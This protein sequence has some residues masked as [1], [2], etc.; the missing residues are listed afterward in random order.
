MMA[1]DMKL[2][3][4]EV[5]LYEMPEFRTNIEQLF[6]TSTIRVEG[7]MRKTVQLDMVT[8]DIELAVQ[9]ADYILVVTPAFAHEG[10]ARLLKGKVTKEQVIVVFP[11]AFAA[12]V[13]KNILG[14]DSPVIADANNLPYDVRLTA[15]CT[16]SLFGRNK[17]NIAFLPADKGPELIDTLREDLFP[18]DKIYTDVL[19][20]GLGI[21]NPALHSGPCLLNISNIESPEVNFFLYQHGFTPSAAKIDIM[22]DNERKA[23]GD[24]LGYHL[25]PIE[26]FSGLSEGYTWQE[27]YRATHGAISL[28]PICGPN[29]IN[30]RYLTEDAPFGLVPWSSIAHLIGVNTPTIDA[31]IRLYN[32]IHETDWVQRGATA[33]SFGI[34]GMSLEEIKSYV[35]TG[36][37]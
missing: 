23:I 11:G 8:D 36:K 24:K 28:T 7:T 9:G 15:P 6:E 20:C 3:G 13:F 16:V 34:D 32:I 22:L 14:D 35:R 33:E 30:N 31:V 25:T 5:R 10:Y 21:V 4:H 29:D 18:F 1:A 17:I 37:K 26:D 27:L 19:E 12:L 2:K